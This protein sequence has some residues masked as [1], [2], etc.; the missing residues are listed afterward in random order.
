M[1][2]REGWNHLEWRWE[3]RNINLG[4]IGKRLNTNKPVWKPGKKVR[5]LLWQEQGIGDVILFTTLIPDFLE[6]VDKLLVKVDKRLIQ[7]FKRSFDNSKIHFISKDVNINESEYDSHISIV[8]LAK[9][10]RPSL[11]SFEKCKKFKIKVDEN[12]SNHLRTNLLTSQYK[13]IIG[14]SWKSKNNLKK[15]INLSLVKLM[16]G[17]QSPNVRF[18]CLQY[19]NVED[20]IYQLKR[21]HGIEIEMIKDIDLF[22]DL[23]SLAALINACDE[24][25]SIENVTLFLAGAIGVKTNIL[26]SNQC[27]WYHGIDSRSSY[28]F[29]SIRLFRQSKSGEWDTP[30]KEIK[31]EIEV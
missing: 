11:E 16:S 20:E 23:D 22:N 3:K 1:D 10:L 15:G 18:I 7:L 8:S 2:F 5:V 14:I 9:F 30:L 6:K 21:L 17:I 28:W 25:I 27:R 4:L 26:L 29:P 12:L 31:E 24:V 19:G 13:K